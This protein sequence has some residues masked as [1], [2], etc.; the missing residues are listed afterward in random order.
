MTFADNLVFSFNLNEG[1]QKAN[2]LIVVSTGKNEL[3]ER[4]AEFKQGSFKES[5]LLFAVMDAAAA[6]I[7]IEA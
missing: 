2:H 7:F 3:S 5:N 4:K 6:S 1:L